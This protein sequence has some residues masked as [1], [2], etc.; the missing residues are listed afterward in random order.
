[1]DRM[2]IYRGMQYLSPLRLVGVA[3]HRRRGLFYGRQR[4]TI[5][6]KYLESQ[7]LVLVVHQP[8]QS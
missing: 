7:A 3:M 5:A 1:M 4:K 2:Q 6:I 8:Q